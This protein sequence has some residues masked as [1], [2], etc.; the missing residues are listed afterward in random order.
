[1][2]IKRR[3]RKGLRFMRRSASGS[4][5]ICRSSDNL[6]LSPGVLAPAFYPSTLARQ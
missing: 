1:L 4:Q 3:I 6:N 2:R 5:V